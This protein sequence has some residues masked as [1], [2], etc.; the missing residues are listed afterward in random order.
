MIF[1]FFVKY[2]K[3]NTGDNY[4]E[5]YIERIVDKEIEERLSYIG[6]VL[7]EGCKWCGKSTTAKQHSKSIVEFQD[8]DKKSEYDYIYNTK[9]S[10]FL[11]GDKP[12]L[13]DEWQMY[14]VI[15]DSIRTN[16]DKTS[17]EGQF[18]LT[19]STKPKEDSKMHTGT[20]RFSRILMRP[21]S[22]YESGES[23]GKVSLKDLMEGKDI[24]AV[25]NI[26]L[27]NI[28]N[29]II[30]GGW[31][32]SIKIKNDNKYKVSKDYIDNLLREDIK[33]IDG[34][35]RNQEKMNVVLKSLARNI[36]T[37]VSNSTLIEDTKNEFENISR[38]TLDDYISTLEK[39]FILE[40]INSTTLSIR[41]KSALRTKPKKIFVD[42]S[43]ATAILGLTKEDLI[44]D[45]N[46][47]GFLFE[48]LCLRDL[49]IYLENNRS[50]IS[51]YRD[52]NDFEIDAIIKNEKGEWGAVEIKLGAGFIEKAVENLLKFKEKIDIKKSGEP[53]FLM[54]LTGSNY[55]FKT[56]EGV[57]VVSIGSLKN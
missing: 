27:E 49:K 9:P 37:Q 4:M 23:D 43:L 57:Y 6:A 17:L 25:N 1:T 54:V 5:K 50:T 47:F 22:L 12:R 33:T 48:N 55:S 32:A 21:M 42:P 31:P 20:G 8:P 41:S 40:N 38:P 36:C 14:P 13:F 56:K 2:D 51:F 53:K 52:E 19:G 29:I 26:T 18:I 24:N 10:L 3:L 30:R 44:K 15:W 7:I 34:T 11:E 35:E 28:A 39:L 16:L 45:L 46:Y